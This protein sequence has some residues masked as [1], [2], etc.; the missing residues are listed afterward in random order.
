M[1]ALLAALV[2]AGCG[3]S[4]ST[5]STTTS[6]STTSAAHAARRLPGATSG[7]RPTLATLH[8]LP[9]ARPHVVRARFAGISGLALPAKL[10][11]LADNVASFW[12]LEFQGAQ[13]QL[14]PASLNLVADTPVT[15]GSRRLSTTDAPLY[16]VPDQSLDLTL[17]FIQ[18]NVEPIGDAA[19]AL[20]VSDIYG[21]HVEN[22]LGAFN[23]SA[24]LGAA[25]L[26]QMDSCF[27]GAYFYYLQAKRVLGPGDEAA[28]NKLLA[29]LA[30]VAG[31]PGASAG[32]SL[33]QLTTAFNQ[34]IESQG[35]AGVCL[36]KRGG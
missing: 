32:A 12:A 17:G 24:G 7:A 9:R 31:S 30:P 28:V 14:T 13:V 3:S 4:S 22:V 16:C 25:Q 26:A 11:T 18:S 29:K 23:P 27:S 19:L 33:D 5:T 10:T 35:N 34:G 1:I 15:C 8:R 2:L 36:P 21:Y 20:L 6:S